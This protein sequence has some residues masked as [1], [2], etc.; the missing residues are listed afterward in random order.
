MLD[1]QLSGGGKGQGGSSVEG[2]TAAA[3]GAV[4]GL[5]A[6][7]TTTP[8]S[9][10]L[11]YTLG[12]LFSVTAMSHVLPPPLI[13]STHLFYWTFLL[14]FKLD[15]ART[16]IMT[17]TTSTSREPLISSNPFTVLEMLYQTEGVQSWFSGTVPRAVRAIASGAIQF[18]SYELVQNYL[19][20]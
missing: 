1:E 15:V 11:T 8:V 10:V 9:T 7:V 6:Q 14:T 19:H 18:A 17:A 4:A 12:M 5:V 2:L 13:Y 3:L 20:P 16:R